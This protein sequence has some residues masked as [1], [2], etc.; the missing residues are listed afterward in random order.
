[1]EN[2]DDDDGST[3]KRRRRLVGEIGDNIPSSEYENFNDTPYEENL[4]TISQYF[5]LTEIELPPSEDI[6]NNSLPQR[7][8]LL[9]VIY[10]ETKVFG[11]LDKVVKKK[12]TDYD[13]FYVFTVITKLN[14]SFPNNEIIRLT[15]VKSLQ[16]TLRIMYGLEKIQDSP[17]FHMIMKPDI[18]DYIISQG[19]PFELDEMMEDNL[20]PSESMMEND[21]NSSEPMISQVSTLEQKL[22]DMQLKIVSS[23]LQT[24]QESKP[25]ICM[26]QGPPGT[27]TDSVLFKVLN[28]RSKLKKSGVEL[29][30]VRVGR[31]GKIDPKVKEVTLSDILKNEYREHVSESK[32]KTAQQHGIEESIIQRA[33]IIASTLTSCYNMKMEIVFG[34]SSGHKIP[35]CIVDEAGQSTE[36][37]SLIPLLLGVKILILVGDPQQLPPTII[38]R[39]AKRHG[40]DVS[41][42]A[43]IQKIFRK[44]SINPIQMLNVQ[45][46]MADE[47]ALWPNKYFYSKEILNDT[48]NGYPYM[49]HYKIFNHN[50]NQSSNRHSNI[51]EA[52]FI[53]DLLDVIIDK[54]IIVKQKSSISIITPYRDQK[55]IISN[56]IEQKLL[57]LNEKSEPKKTEYWENIDVNTVDS[58]QGQEQDIIIMSCVRSKGI[59][60]VSDPNR[61]N[62]SLTRAKH[63]MILFGNFEAFKSNKMWCA[64]LDDAKKRNAYIDINRKTQYKDFKKLI[65]SHN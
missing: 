5:K 31:D 41:L 17:L 27:A 53:C 44:E 10:N 48:K 56:N 23:I 62:V 20:N 38:S 12:R 9:H 6:N 64:L 37:A 33:D 47:I 4:V 39:D 30:I 49:C 45:Y 3:Y 8:D 46:R 61:L 11:Y 58:F 18:N 59:G 32:N 55:R 1:M 52:K 13:Y 29:N 7:G 65:F 60:F 34:Q 63:S 26:V 42:F 51:K 28:I 22:N 57:D 54:L 16:Q 50:E 40:M 43:R 19:K 2:I 21:S 36:L 14:I 25:K 24:V 35:I 15:S